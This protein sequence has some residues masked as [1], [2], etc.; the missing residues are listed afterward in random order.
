LG[1]H[2]EAASARLGSVLE[3]LQVRLLALGFEQRP[4]ARGES[5]VFGFRM[6]IGL[7]LADRPGIREDGAIVEDKK[8]TARLR[9]FLHGELSGIPG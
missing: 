2:D 5:R 6:G 4:T 1:S 7:A 9:D 3:R 8:S